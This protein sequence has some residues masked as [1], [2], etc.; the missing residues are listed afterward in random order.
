[1][2]EPPI[3]V[4]YIF[5]RPRWVDNIYGSGLE[6]T[7]NQTRVLPESLALKF[8]RHTDT[9]VRDDAHV[10]TLKTTEQE[11]QEAVA[12]AEARANEQ[13]AR[14]QQ[15]FEVFLLLDQMEKEPLAQYVRER[16]ALSLD[17]T[18]NIDAMRIEAKA[19]IDRFGLV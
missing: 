1:M 13:A 12:A 10:V 4:K 3:P 7:T 2:N 15:K 8:L 5:R 6:F 17:E 16:F 19:L 11:T 14:D 18:A 9:F